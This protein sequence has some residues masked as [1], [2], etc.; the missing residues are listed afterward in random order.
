[1][2]GIQSSRQTDIEKRS[3]RY[4]GFLVLFCAALAGCSAIN[5][6][7]MCGYDGCPAD[8]AITSEVVAQLKRHPAL[9]P[10]DSIRVETLGG[11]VYLTGQVTTDY[12]R[13]IAES[14]ARQAAGESRIVNS[15][16]LPYSGR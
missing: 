11:V 12:Q 8:R 5:V 7:R 16:A 6:Y 13:Q 2:T 15:L 9:G 10:P 4:V 3:V 14:A 1:M